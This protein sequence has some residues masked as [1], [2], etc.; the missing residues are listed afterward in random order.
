MH[1]G[2]VGHI[3]GVHGSLGGQHIF[4]SRGVKWH[5]LRLVAGDVGCGQS[6]QS[7]VDYGG[8]GAFLGKYAGFLPLGEGGVEGFL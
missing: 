5:E 6:L 4:S 1:D 3:P 8:W 2:M 7:A